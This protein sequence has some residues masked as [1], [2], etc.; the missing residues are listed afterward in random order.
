MSG[1]P[2]EVLLTRIREI[3][4]RGD[5]DPVRDA[6]KIAAV[7]TAI[8][9]WSGN[10]ATTEK[11]VQWAITEAKKLGLVMSE[12]AGAEELGSVTITTTAEDDSLWMEII[13]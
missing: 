3:L 5:S 4:T 11:D 7:L 10:P 13:S 2:C 8:D 12:L 9:W 6:G 1:L